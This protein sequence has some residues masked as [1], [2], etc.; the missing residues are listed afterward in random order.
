MYQ[1]VPPDERHQ[2]I[3]EAAYFRAEHRG[4]QGGCPV[5]DW[6][7]AERETDKLFSQPLPPRGALVF[8]A[9]NHN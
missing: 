2:L 8:L 6:L 1:I 7:E 9:G 3:A 5:Q 4:F